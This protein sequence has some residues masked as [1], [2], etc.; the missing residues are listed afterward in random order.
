MIQKERRNDSVG[1]C[2]GS[3]AII[4][5]IEIPA[6]RY[7]LLS[8]EGLSKALRV[9]LGF[10]LP[11][12]YIADVPKETI[13]VKP[14]TGQIR[15]YV[16]AAILRNVSLDETSYQSFISLQDKLHANVCRYV[17]CAFF[18]WIIDFFDLESVH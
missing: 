17:L 9:F 6:N 1:L 13:Y 10:S 2:D 12:Q 18:C 11:P 4:Y 3:D 8:L 5:R 16:V 14:A 15:K 7:D